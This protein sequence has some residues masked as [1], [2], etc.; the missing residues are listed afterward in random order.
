MAEFESSVTVKCP[1][2]KAFDFLL[3]PENVAK[4]SPPN[5]GL[6]FVNAPEIVEPGSRIEFQIQAFGQIQTFTHEITVVERPRKIIEKQVSGL[7]KT[8]V[9]EHLFEERDPET[10]VIVD[11]IVFEPPGGLIGLLLFGLVAIFVSIPN[12]NLIW[13]VGGLVVFAG[14]TV[15]DFWRLRRAGNGDVG[16]SQAPD[17]GRVVGGLV[18]EDVERGRQ[19]FVGHRRDHRSHDLVEIRGLRRPGIQR[20]EVRR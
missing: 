20:R 19:A 8:W 15:F 18:A 3:R 1:V 9:H 6:R 4:I 16:G 14:L 7:F 10:T 5:V 13:A 11:Q 17:V 2:E 12:E